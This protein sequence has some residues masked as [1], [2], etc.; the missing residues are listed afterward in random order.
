MAT[1]MT[2]ERKYYEFTIDE[3]NRTSKKVAKQEEE[4][5]EAKNSFLF[6]CKTFLERQI[7]FFGEE[8]L[9]LGENTF[10]YMLDYDDEELNYTVNIT[11]VKGKTYDTLVAFDENEEEYPLE[12]MDYDF[13][14]GLTYFVCKQYCID[15]KVGGES[16]GNKG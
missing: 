4:L 16:N 2:P 14:L 9:N 7:N 8:Q 15:F 13:I 5:Q 6:A 11:G 1:T 10:T 12:E 3:L